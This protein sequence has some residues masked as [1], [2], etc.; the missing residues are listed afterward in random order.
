M[1]KS[2][3]TI[4]FDLDGTLVDTSAGI[5]DS[6]R[7]TI[8]RLH[9]PVLDEDAMRTFIGPPLSFSFEK[10]FGMEQ[11]AIEIAISTFREYY[12]EKGIYNAEIY[13][14]IE[15]LLCSLKQ[16]SYNLGVA[17]YK[18]EDFAIEVLKHMHI[19]DYFDVVHGADSDG[20]IKK[21]E[22]IE[23][24]AKDLKVEK[25]RCLYVGDTQADADAALKAGVHFCAVD[26]GFGYPKSVVP[27]DICC[28]SQPIELLSIEEFKSISKHS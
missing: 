26:W 20:K 4:L 22:I 3:D 27:E 14:G 7:F 17:T 1:R 21:S 23:L 12:G 18:R 28:I 13:N 2:F 8:D 16:K 5:L 15:D 25:K 11:K 10:Y 19:S 24:C 6:I 9:L